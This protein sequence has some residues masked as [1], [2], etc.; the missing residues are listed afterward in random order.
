MFGEHFLNLLGFQIYTHTHARTHTHTEDNTSV[1]STRPTE[2]PGLPAK[3]RVYYVILSTKTATFLLLTTQNAFRM[4][5]KMINNF[6][7]VSVCL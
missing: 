3:N 2:R 5:A 7:L 4:L 6:A 1:T